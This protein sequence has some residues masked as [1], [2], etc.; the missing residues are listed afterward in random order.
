MSLDAAAIA[1]MLRS[2]DGPVF[3]HLSVVATRI[4]ART[5]ASLKE[6]FPSEF[7]GPRIVKR[8]GQDSASLF[9]EIGSSVVTTR[10]HPIVGNPILAFPWPKRGGGVF[11]F[12]SVQHP[13]SNFGPYLRGKLLEAVAAERNTP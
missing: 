9:V 4:Q 6:G 3:R 10:P 2:Q 5:K 11:Y 12:R 13:G 8:F 7:L 1:A